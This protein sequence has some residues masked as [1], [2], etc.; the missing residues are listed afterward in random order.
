[1]SSDR[2][3][4]RFNSECKRADSVKEK[5]I[6]EVMEK[7]SLSDAKMEP[8]HPNIDFQITHADGTLCFRN[9]GEVLLMLIGGDLDCF[10]SIIKISKH[11]LVS[12]D[13]VSKELKILAISRY[14]Y[15]SVDSYEESLFLT[16]RDHGS[17]L[18]R[19]RPGTC[20][21]PT[22]RTSCR[23]PVRSSCFF[24]FPVLFT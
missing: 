15:C 8:L 10:G 17:F 23:I 21:L 19:K 12:V 18:L 13:L 4:R 14:Q 7:L 5:S 2:E 11:E 1:M 16:R 20:S 24:C 6:L 9:N 3:D 22:N